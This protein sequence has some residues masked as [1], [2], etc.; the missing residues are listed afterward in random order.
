MDTS[1]LSNGDKE[2][3]ATDRIS[4]A[5]SVR[6]S[7]QMDIPAPPAPTPPPTLPPLPLLR[8]HTLANDDQPGLC[9]PLNS[10]LKLTQLTS[11]TLSPCSLALF[12]RF[13]PPLPRQLEAHSPLPQRTPPSS[14]PLPKTKTKT[15]TPHPLVILP[16]STM[17][18]KK[19][20]YQS[21]PGLS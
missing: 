18:S 6:R 14:F 1:L 8:P 16:A 4:A 13:Q 5:C 7:A 15:K 21:S 9:P 17:R 12:S 2:A 10:D 3:R 11:T 20:G 19:R